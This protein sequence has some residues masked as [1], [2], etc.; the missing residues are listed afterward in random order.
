M[1]TEADL[2]HMSW[3]R[4]YQD[5]EVS[6]V[7]DDDLTKGR[8]LC[9]QM[10]YEF[11]IMSVSL[12]DIQKQNLTSE[13]EYTSEHGFLSFS[14]P[15]SPRNRRLKGLNLTF[16]Y[17]IQGDTWVW[18][19]K[20]KTNKGV[21]LI[22]NPKVF[23][24]PASDEVGV[25]ISYWPIGESLQD[26]DVVD[27]AIVVMIGLEIQGCGASLVYT[28]DEDETKSFEDNDVTMVDANTI[29]EDNNN[30]SEDSNDHADIL[31][32]DISRFKL[33]TGTYYLC[34]RDYSE[35][36]EVGRLT[37]K[38][39]YNLVG[40]TIDYTGT[41]NSV[42]F[43]TYYRMLIV[44]LIVTEIGGW[45]K[46]GR[47]DQ[48]YGSYTELKT[49]R[50]II[51]GPELEEIYKIA[52]STKSSLLDATVEAADTDRTTES[53]S[54]SLIEKK[55]YT[56]SDLSRSSIQLLLIQKTCRFNS[57]VELSKFLGSLDALP[58]AYHAILET[59]SAYQLHEAPE[60]QILAFTITPDYTARFLK[61]E[62][63]LVSSKN[64]K[65]VEFISTKVNPLFSINKAAFDLFE[66]LL[67][68]LSQ[69][70]HQLAYK[71]LIVTGQSLGG[72]LAILFTLWLQHE[73]DM[74]ESK[75]RRNNKRPICI[76]FGSPLVGDVAL[77][78]AIRERPTWKSCFLNVVTK[79]DPVASL[80]S[81]KTSYKPFG[82]FL[83][84]TESGSN[85]VFEDPELI[86][87]VLD[88]MG[89]SNAGNLEMSD[90]GNNLRETRRKLLYRGVSES[91]E[92]YLN[93]F[94]AGITLQLKEVGVSDNISENLIGRMEKEQ[95]KM[96]RSNNIYESIRKITDMKI[97]MTYMEFYMKN[98]RSK[99]GYYVS[100][101]DAKT[102]EKIIS[103]AAIIRHQRLLNQYWRKFV[104][105]KDLMPQEEGVNLRKRWL[106]S[107]NKYRKIVEPLEIAEYY[108]NGKTNYVDKRPFHYKLLEKW[109]NEDREMSNTSDRNE[110][111]AASLNEDSCFWAQVEEALISLRGLRNGGS[112]KNA[113]DLECELEKFED[114]L[115]LAINDYKVSPDIFLEGSSLMKWWNEYKEYRG[116]SYASEFANFMNNKSYLSYQ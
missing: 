27:V 104:E 51:Y 75:G 30:T 106:Y 41:F 82:T 103:K 39:F 63:D 102:R 14:V 70:R 9:L 46:T 8:S 59:S 81:S 90:Y 29:L 12:P 53:T 4:P 69:I 110:S 73:V 58:N 64:H 54:S 7:G 19:A 98:T 1:L 20:I 3:L 72:Y 60:I 68:E 84:C 80:F 92:L 83:F 49:V 113:F 65:V 5:C 76:T 94:R 56:G 36:M 67:L 115:M 61:G 38:W 100:F 18:F 47:P 44:L 55:E 10:L 85:S 37:P 57:K 97:S 74:E 48:P 114:Y 101:K 34:C 28:D 96:M 93:L 6:L 23:G 112:S 91:G 16:K 87:A 11:N 105:E 33:S 116:D 99:G 43:K 17:T 42:E 88:S 108:K 77:Q 71:P 32:A 78:L 45:R 66:H 89:S 24:K 25:W 62:F 107:G 2:G 86:L 22:Y 95:K 35:L 15:K 21:D 40:D 13:Y 109:L 111:K 52:E 79:K 50:C 31:G 26:K